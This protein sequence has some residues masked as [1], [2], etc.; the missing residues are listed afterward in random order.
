MTTVLVILGILLYAGP[1]TLVYL[2][3]RRSG[4]EQGFRD[5]TAD[6]RRAAQEFGKHYSDWTVRNGSNG[7]WDA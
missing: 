6:A 3:A 5:G 2:A 7:N 4:Y 1:C